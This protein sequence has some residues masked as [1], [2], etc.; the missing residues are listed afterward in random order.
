MPLKR[1]VRARS[2]QQV[3]LGEAYSEAKGYERI[4]LFG[5]PTGVRRRTQKLVYA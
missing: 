1:R 4:G 5:R 2:T 3:G